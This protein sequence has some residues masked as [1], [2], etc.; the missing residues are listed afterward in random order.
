MTP[1]RLLLPVREGLDLPA[2]ELP[3]TPGLR[4]IVGRN[5]AGKSRFLTSLR[6][7]HLIAECTFKELNLLNSAPQNLHRLIDSGADFAVR[8][9][10][11]GRL[12]GLGRQAAH[13]RF[14]LDNGEVEVGKDFRALVWNIHQCNPERAGENPSEVDGGFWGS[15]GVLIQ[16]RTTVRRAFL[17]PTNRHFPEKADLNNAGGVDN[18]EQW[19]PLLVSLGDSLDREKRRQ[20]D[21]IRETFAAVTGGLQINFRGAQATRAVYIVEP[22]TE[23]HPLAACG[24]GLRDLIALLMLIALHPVEDLLV[25][26]PGIR[27][28]Q[29]A[30]RRILHVLEEAADK[31]QVWI[32]TH[33]G[34]FAGAR[35]AVARYSVRRADAL[36]SQVRGI[37]G[38]AELREANIDLGWQPGD[39]FLADR[40]L[41]CEGPSDKVMF[42]ALVADLSSTDA[43]LGG[44]LVT[45]LGGCGVVWANDRQA[46]LRNLDLLRRVAPHAQHVVLLDRDGR[47]Q[48]EIDAMAAAVRAKA[49]LPVEWLKDEELE[50]SFLVPEFVALLLREHAAARSVSI[51]DDA[52]AAAIARRLGPEEKRKGSEVLEE[53]HQELKLGYEKVLG[54]KIAARHLRTVAPGKHAELLEQLRA[55]LAK[56]ETPGS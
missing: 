6:D 42:E 20:A 38:V 22:G 36:Q 1:A 45:D 32:T 52:I 8:W 16:K 3:L 39:A 26:E 55:V 44:T 31:R 17:V 19:A 53:V 18:P 14:S 41:Y 7:A 37:A 5:N 46:L 28:H 48:R 40:V 10:R 2:Q 25:E 51:L 50:S 47:A 21:W 12:V 4:V 54:A 34:V 24:D 29:G 9:N 33:D 43:S 30:Q 56:A 35:S 23:G 49:G 15:L 11:E 27:L 13:Q